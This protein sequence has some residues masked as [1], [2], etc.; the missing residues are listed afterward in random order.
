M[1]RTGQVTCVFVSAIALLLGIERGASAAGLTEEEV[2][3]RTASTSPLTEE[4]KRDLE[5]ALA[6]R[7]KAIS[8]F[9]PRL[10]LSASYYRLSPVTNAPIAGFE[11]KS[12][13]NQTSTSATL[14][15]PL[16]DYVFRLVQANDS[17]R[18]QVTA[19]DQT[20]KAQ[21][22]KTVYDGKTLYWQWVRSELEV[23]VANQN[24]ELS[25]EHLARM[26]T[27]AAHDSASEADVAR[28][29]SSAASAE[30]VVLQQKNV[31]LLSRERLAIAMHAT[32]PGDWQVAEDLRTNPPPP[33]ALT[34]PESLVRSAQSRRPEV[35][36]ANASVLAST[37]QIEVARAQAF[38]RLDAIA[39]ATMAN[40]N[41]RRIPPTQD[42]HS[43][44]QI[45]MQLSYAPND[46]ATGL[47]QTAAARARADAADAKRRQLLDAVRSEV[48]EAVIAHR[49]ATASHET[50]TRRLAAAETSYRARRQLFENDRAT[51]VELT[52]AQTE[53]FRARLD[54]VQ[55]AV[56]VRVAN[57]RLAYATGTP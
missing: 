33:V 21:E 38:P 8:D 36:A 24:L 7:D 55:A 6:Q 1:S 50:A 9:F 32:G 25:K 23:A 29:E 18:A 47:S 57:A 54:V 41:Q 42:F 35:Q 28:V 40:P 26:R 53:L 43:S 51:T 31:V 10:A 49:D 46:T 48:V 56:G 37:K 5:A 12:L 39:N 45:G 3:R 13:E 27:L 22:R 15:V 2:A 30:L 34:D 4:K 20:L 19:S 11:I 14:T 17:A 16:T 44:W 52:E